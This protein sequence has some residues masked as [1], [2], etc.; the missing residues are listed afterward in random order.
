MPKLFITSDGSTLEIDFITVLKFSFKLSTIESNPLVSLS[1]S[2]FKKEIF[3]TISFFCESS[4]RIASKRK[5]ISERVSFCETTSRENTE[6]F[7]ATISNSSFTS[8]D[9]NVSELFFS[10]LEKRDSIAPNFESRTL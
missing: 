9:F 10:R 3:L 7:V 8:L 6:R 5:V 4:E 1:R 2:F